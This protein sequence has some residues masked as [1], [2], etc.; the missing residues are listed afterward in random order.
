MR[1]RELD[2]AGSGW[3]QV[4]LSCEHCSERVGSIKCSEV[5]SWWLVKRKCALWRVSVSEW[6]VAWLVA[7][8]GVCFV[9]YQCLWVAGGVAVCLGR[10][11]VLCGVSMSLSGWWRVQ[12]ECAL[13]S[14]SV[15]EWLVAW[16]VEGLVTECWDGEG[17]E[18]NHSCLMKALSVHWL[19]GFEENHKNSI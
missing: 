12:K 15:S 3:V 8:E 13:W 6:L 5:R 7:W 16:L 18:G 2:W 10:K 11:S 1:S 19:G 4:V 14:V 17:R 9:E